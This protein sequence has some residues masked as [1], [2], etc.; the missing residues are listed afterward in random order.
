MHDAAKEVPELKK[1]KFPT[2]DCTFAYL[3]LIFVTRESWLVSSS[4]LAAS[5]ENARR[6]DVFF[7]SWPKTAF[8]TDVQSQLASVL[9]TFTELLCCA[10]ILPQGCEIYKEIFSLCEHLATSTD[11]IRPNLFLNPRQDFGRIPRPRKRSFPF[12]ASCPTRHVEHR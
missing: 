11:I 3:C 1:K 12:E 2:E 4:E 6:R 9:K 7:R 8:P 10:V 5:Y